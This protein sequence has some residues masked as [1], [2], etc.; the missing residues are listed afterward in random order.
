MLNIH[1]LPLLLGISVASSLDPRQS[2]QAQ[3]PCAELSD[4]AQDNDTLLPADLALSCLRSV[5][6]FKDE[7]ALQLA[8]LKVF[9][10]FQS[11]LD[12]YGE[13]MP[14]GW[15]YPAVNLTSS[16]E[17]L[18]QKLEDDF[19]ENEYDF[20][21]DLY[22]LVSS[23]Y[24]GHLVYVPDI[25]GVFQFLRVK[26]VADRSSSRGIQ[27]EDLFSL[28]SVVQGDDELPSVFA[29]DDL[30]AMQDEKDAGYEP[31]S[32]EQI[33]GEDVESWL[34]S[35][36]SQNGR[37]R[38]PDANYNSL[39][40][41]LPGN[42][43]IAAGGDAFGYSILYQ[44]TET[45]LGFTN[46]TNR[47]VSTVAA[48]ASNQ[49][50][51]GVT[52][53]RTFFQRFCNTTYEEKVL[54]LLQDSGTDPSNTTRP[55]TTT[56]VPYEPVSTQ[57]LAP[58]NDAFP[59]PIIA[60]LDG[61]IAGYFPGDQLEDLAVLS[62]PS[63]LSLQAGSVEFENAV[64]QTLATANANNK[65]KLVI[66]LRGNG[67]G[68][69]FLAY[70][71]F[72]Q[73]FPS[74]T[75]YGA[76]TYRQQQLFNFTGSTLSS[77]T[78]ALAPQAVNDELYIASFPFD[79]RSAL[80]AKGNPFESWDSLY[81]GNENDAGAWTSL[82]RYN[83]TEVSD[84]SVPILGYG[85]DTMFQ[86][87]TFDADNIVMLTD[88]TCASTCAIFSEFMKSQAGVKSVAVGG[89]KQTGPMQAVGGTKG[90][91]V[92]GMAQ[93][94]SLVTSAAQ[95]AS[96]EDQLR[97][98]NSFDTDEGNLLTATTKA[99]DRAA[100]GSDLIVQ[101]GVNFRNNIRKG[102]DTL[103]PLQFIYEAADCRFFYTPEMYARQEAIWERV[104]QW[105]WGN[106]ENICIEGSSGRDSSK[107]GTSYYGTD[108]PGNAGNF[109]GGNNTIFPRDSLSLAA[110]NGTETS[111]GGSSSGTST[112]S[113][114][115]SSQDGSNGGNGQDSENGASVLLASRAVGEHV[116]LNTGWRFSRFETNPDGVIYD[117]RP[118]LENLTDATVLKPWI[119]P[120]ANR[121]I[122]DPANHFET[123][124]GPPP[125][126]VP[127]AQI[128]FD[129]S[130]WELVNVPHDWAIDGPFYTDEEDPVVGGGMGRLPIQGV[131]WYR[132]TVHIDQSDVGKAISLD[133][134]GAMSYA[135]VWVNGDLN[136][137]WPYPYNS[138]SLDLSSNLKYGED[139]LIAI[140]LDNPN[141]SARWY[142]GAGLYRNVYLTK[143]NPAQIGRYGT[144]LT[145]SDITDD[146]ATV[147]VIVQVENA[148][149]RSAHVQV[150]TD[151]YSVEQH[152]R[153][154]KVAQS[155][156]SSAKLSPG[157]HAAVDQ[158]IRLPDPRLWGPRPEQTPNLYTAVTRLYAG[159]KAID[160]YS[161]EFGIRSVVFDPNQGLL[162]NGYHVPVQGVNL[163]H[164]LG[165]Q[166]AAFNTRAAE[167]QLETLQEMGFNALRT[168]HNPPAR[169]VL[170]LADRMGIV[171]MDEIFD[172][173]EYNKTDN[174]F[175]LIFPEWHE[176]DLRNFIRRDHNHPSIVAWSYGNEVIDQTLNET[177]PVLSRKLREIV[178]EEDSTRLSTASVN[179][180]K[181]SWPF[182]ETLEIIS[183]NYQGQGIR[184]G[185]QY[186]NLS[187]IITPPVYP[188]F[189]S[190]LP[191]KPILSSETSATVDTRGTYIF[192]VVDA[193]SAPA[194]ESSGT[195]PEDGFV[196]AY[197]L[198][199]ANFGASPDKTFAS[200]DRNPYVAGEFVWAGIDYLG[201]PTP[202]YTS[203]SSYFGIVDLAGF[204]KDRYYQYQARWRPGLPVAHI[205][206]HW[207][208]SGREG[209]VTP[210]HVFSEADE[211]EL[212]LNG[213]SQGRMVR[214]EYEYRFRWDEVRYEPGT[215]FVQT[216]RNGGA[217]AND[218]V[219]T[220]SEPSDLRLMADRSEIEG[221]GADL[222]FVTLE[223]VDAHGH[224][225]PTA[226][227]NVTFALDGPGEIVATDNG[228]P[229]SFVAFSSLTREAF[230]GK[231]LAIVRAHAGVHG[232]LK[233][234]ATSEGLDAG[235]VPIKVR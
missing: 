69:T 83:L 163:H 43:S 228:D 176:P 58:T 13:Q 155:S 229:T 18:T 76:G 107:N 145:T 123:P 2:G 188:D 102:D 98:L 39:F 89:R 125:V 156:P 200:L 139:N 137:G 202:F 138:F 15:I 29:Y 189:H 22:K 17:E 28:M 56:Q 40:Q 124:E 185:P 197:G 108:L 35:Y 112:E 25:V 109:F 219:C 210:V 131:G 41:N 8:G 77:N 226:A 235:H 74:Q 4:L 90:S 158:T 73:L 168:A 5:P 223:V 65:T 136:G 227:N 44:G 169:E 234:V 92:L 23:A 19:Y 50:L 159:H 230:S 191:K 49:T 215:L 160:Q 32:I 52:D 119:L 182:P 79:Y 118:D 233:L 179:S 206:P 232:L 171:V 116:S 147:N 130:S 212:F 180:A 72:L 174:D 24:D 59:S 84:L 132:Q 207:N 167:R 144:Y 196:S 224:V 100:P 103:T 195:D 216:Y 53:G 231:A 225:V 187:G 87:Q 54:Q 178:S 37:S 161:T 86:R 204:P 21:L 57:Y 193:D 91:R 45:I 66:D 157:G 153:P 63:F 221:D 214:G 10:E 142:P 141:E 34:N 97:L 217:W 184:T 205:L 36:A 6:L 120:T 81:D 64:R 149:A 26:S 105:A 190:T 75:P 80:D 11:D 110:E 143:T 78:D 213:R 122:P 211:A 201:E 148:G 60:S 14:P 99:L 146:S 9:L 220:T 106:E 104:Y 7:D 175:H 150:V 115:E 42:G 113:S 3:E 166:G 181:A 140:R 164:D 31:S 114:G 173:W 127:Y 172:T 198:Y 55:T 27:S 194:N 154:C 177:G 30:D 101:A 129:D 88:G 165:A 38:D 68:S 20:Q 71:L 126:E 199:T 96:P 48:L 16:L 128:S 208:W 62:I 111:S 183:L 134:E 203:R 12:Y 152:G 222:A 151:I 82:V 61:N 170:T 186:S 192:P 209:E 117:Y 46:G 133:I 121:Y 218:T 85:N 135:M 70:D 95:A 51:E 162:I 93:L 47:S 67:G 1:T 33:N 94:Y